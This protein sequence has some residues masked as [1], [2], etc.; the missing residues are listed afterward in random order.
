MKENFDKAVEYVNNMKDNVR[1]TDKV[2]EALYGMYKRITV[3]KCSEKGG[4]RPMMF[5][6]IGQTKYDAWMRYD[7]KNEEE[8]KK[9][10][11]NLVNTLK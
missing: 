7:D 8:C 6:I 2:K 10:Y 1:A 11:I 3:G 5:N 9:L 4:T